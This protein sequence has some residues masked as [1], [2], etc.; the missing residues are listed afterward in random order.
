MEKRGEKRKD[1]G[2][3]MREGGKL[4]RK[5]GTKGRRGK[6]YRGEEKRGDERRREK[7]G[8]ERRKRGSI[9]PL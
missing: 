9:G 5:R 8:E 1:I 4:R 6:R 7:G 2:E 3:E